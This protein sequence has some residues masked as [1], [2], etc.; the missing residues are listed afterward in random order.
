MTTIAQR[1]NPMFVGYGPR[2]ESKCS[3]AK[4]TKKLWLEAFHVSLGVQLYL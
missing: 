3:F 2:Y 1:L 4:D